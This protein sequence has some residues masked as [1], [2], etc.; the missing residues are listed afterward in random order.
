[1]ERKIK[2]Y[3]VLITGND[4]PHNVV[5]AVRIF[6]AAQSKLADYPAFHQLAL[7]LQKEENKQ[8]KIFTHL[9]NLD[10]ISQSPAMVAKAKVHVKMAA[11]VIILLL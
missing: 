11:A 2:K 7:M 9:A 4:Y 8:R 10:S 1:M 3:K 5:L 6:K